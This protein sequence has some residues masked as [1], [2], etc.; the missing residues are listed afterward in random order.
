MV[1][2][3]MPRKLKGK[4]GGKSADAG[5]G[6]SPSKHFPPMADPKKKMK[7]NTVGKAKG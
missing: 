3:T 1:K 6:T 7:K 5:R 4:G 2:T